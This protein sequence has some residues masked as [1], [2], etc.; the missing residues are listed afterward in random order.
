[1][2]FQDQESIQLGPWSLGHSGPFL[3]K[4]EWHEFWLLVR[5]GLAPVLAAK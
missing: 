1:M 2:V 4:I 3:Q 5:P